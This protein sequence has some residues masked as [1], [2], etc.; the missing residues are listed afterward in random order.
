MGRGIEFN[1]KNKVDADALLENVAVQAQTTQRNDMIRADE[2]LDMEFEPLEFVVDGVIATGLTLLVAAPKI[3]KS[4]M[5]LD[6]AYQ[7]ARG[8]KAFGVIPV[9]PRPVLYF[10]LEDGQRRL[11]AR[12]RKLGCCKTAG[13]YFITKTSDIDADI[14]DFMQVHAKNHPLV[15]VDTLQKY[16]ET[17]PASRNDSAYERDYAIV[18]GLQRRVLE[19]EGSLLILHHDR[20]AGS[21]DFVE[22]VSGTNG[23]AGSADTIITINRPRVAADA[24]LSVTSRDAME[25][26]YAVRFDDGR[27]VLEGSDLE[28][29]AQ[30]VVQA[31][32][33][34][35]N[36]DRMNDVLDF[37]TQHPNGVQPLEVSEAL[38]DISPNTATQC[39]IRLFK[40]GSITKLKRG[41]YAPIA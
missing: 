37:V 38:G 23:I 25:G 34:A 6:L 19:A 32:V 2:L 22:A 30:A 35:R 3:G 9:Q 10:A 21:G 31:R 11:N 8:G 27:W 26:E 13:L 5:A 39:L 17:K 7:V 33:H 24:V 1:T 40:A 29:A 16:R 12:M 4:W 36:G 41:V 14:D 15:I 20:K 28:Q 18:G